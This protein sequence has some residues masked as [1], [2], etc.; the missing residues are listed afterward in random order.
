MRRSPC[1]L[2]ALLAALLGAPAEALGQHGLRLG[3][4]GQYVDQ[5]GPLGGF[6]GLGL[7]LSASVGLARWVGVRAEGDFA[8]L[9]AG[10][11]IAICIPVTGGCLA[12]PSA[13]SLLGLTGAVEVRVPFPVVAPF[14]AAG[15][16]YRR[17]I[18][19]KLPGGSRRAWVE[20]SVEAGA[21]VALGGVEWSLSARWR[22]GDRWLDGDPYSELGLLVG[23]RF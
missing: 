18:G 16:T 17:A 10:D 6:S 22:R 11:Q 9:R 12:Q 2:G 13:H 1:F 4:A 3:A 15:P 21:R 5:N 14:L 19:S 23:L 7:V 20:P 8:A